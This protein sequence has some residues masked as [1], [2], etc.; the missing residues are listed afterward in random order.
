MNISL[1][2][3]DNDRWGSGRDDRAGTGHIIL[4]LTDRRTHDSPDLLE[5][6]QQHG[7]E[8]LQ[9]FLKKNEHLSSERLVRNAAPGVIREWERSAEQSSF[10]PLDTLTAYW[11]I[12][13]RQE[14]QA[15]NLRKQLHDMPEISNAYHETS[16]W[17]ACPP[18]GSA[19][20]NPYFLD[21]GYLNA[22]PQGI[23]ARGAWAGT[24][25][26]GSG[27]NVIDLE[28]GWI[29]DHRDLPRPQLLY[30]D[31]GKADGYSSGNHGAAA[32][33]VIGGVDN[34]I[35]I[36]G[37]TPRVNSLNAV[38]HYDAAKKIALHVADAITAAINHLSPGDILLLEVQ[39]YD[40]QNAYPTEIDSADLHAIRLAVAHGIVVIEAAG[41]G[42]RD[43]DEWPDPTGQHSL[44]VN[45]NTHHDSGAIMVG[46][47]S[48]AVVQ[49]PAGSEGHERY[50][51]SNYGSRVD[52]Y[53][54]GEGIYTTGYGTLAG[55]SGA[56]D[57]YAFNFG[58]TSGASAIIAGAAALVQSWYRS[59]HGDSLGSEE[60]RSRLSHPSTSTPQALVSNDSIGVMP[61]VEAIVTGGPGPGHK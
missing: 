42:E 13:V 21:Q 38:S 54:W 4:R 58:Q 51:T 46:S 60:M 52:V 7:Y 37:I 22:G 30:G 23:G 5:L 3:T 18:A 17:D 25:C 53:A 35:G 8:N 11:R 56:I 28:S 10:V 61:D 12:D 6:A 44:D 45:L 55:H 49:D 1:A 39:R 34:A 41:N 19:N 29:L 9:A 20:A 15:E 27:V 43:L 33:G 26:D 47:C 57:S 50:Y 48:S 36:I 16:I 24:H 40:G 32:M 31:N 14:A 2:R 59:K